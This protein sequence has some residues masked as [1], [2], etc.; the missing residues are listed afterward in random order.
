MR[1]QEAVSL[2]AQASVLETENEHLFSEIGRAQIHLQ[3]S[4]G[5]SAGNTVVKLP[6]SKS[7]KTFVSR[8]AAFLKLK[9]P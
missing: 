3:E 7:A 2:D 5:S 1:E 4:A 8:N 9:R 6:E